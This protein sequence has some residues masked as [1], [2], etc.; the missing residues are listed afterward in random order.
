M[1]AEIGVGEVLAIRHPS[2]GDF[3]GEP[4]VGERL[5][6]G[7]YE[8]FEL[9]YEDDGSVR[10]HSEALNLELQWIDGRVALLGPCEGGASAKSAGGAGRAS[11]GAGTNSSDAE[12]SRSSSGRG[13]LAAR[14]EAEL[15]LTMRWRIARDGGRIVPPIA[16][17]TASYE[18]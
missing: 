6:N 3:Y 11:K 16:P 12:R 7:K 9:R 15:R 4:L 10:S 17:S 13:A 18:G 1:Y 8:R 14:L 5:V 2:G